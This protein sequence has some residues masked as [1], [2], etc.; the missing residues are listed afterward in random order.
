MSF[1]ETQ[2]GVGGL[3][4]VA[5]ATVH[6]S[7]V[8]DQ[9]PHTPEDEFEVEIWEKMPNRRHILVMDRPLLERFVKQARKA[10]EDQ[11]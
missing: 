2:G 9:Q 7:T 1:G 10:L 3:F 11:G 5:R 6:R 8:S 4:L